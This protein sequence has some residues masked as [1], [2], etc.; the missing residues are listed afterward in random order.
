MYSSI[1]R[2]GQTLQNPTALQKAVAQES[3][4]PFAMFA[5]LPL[6]VSIYVPSKYYFFESIALDSVVDKEENINQGV[7]EVHTEATDIRL[8]KEGKNVTFLTGRHQVLVIIM[9]IVFNHLTGDPNRLG[10]TGD[11]NQRFQSIH[12]TAINTVIGPSMRSLIHVNPTKCNYPV[13]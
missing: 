2:A 4:T 8:W 6:A 5:S 13:D 1:T 7:P 10:N 11:S 9:C 12:L 3:Q